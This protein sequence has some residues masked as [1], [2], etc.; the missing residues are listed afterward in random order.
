MLYTIRSIPFGLWL[1]IVG[2]ILFGIF[3]VHDERQHGLALI[4]HWAEQ[5]GFTIVSV[6]R[7][8]LV[9]PRLGLQF[10]YISFFRVSLKDA[11]DTTKECWLRI[12]DGAPDP[13]D[14]DVFWDTKS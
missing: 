12:Y 1:G 5:H 13:N 2:G 8:T 3:W 6:K 4:A 11:A 10:P 7:R 9:P 14:I